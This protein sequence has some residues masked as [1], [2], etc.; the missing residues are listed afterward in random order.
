[1]QVSILVV[2]DEPAIQE[3]I[4][5]NLTLSGYQVLR[6]NDAEAAAALLRDNLPDMMLVDWMLPGQSGVNLIRALRAQTRTRELPIIMLTARGEQQDKILGLESGADDYMTK[7]FSPREMIARIQALLRRRAPQASVEVIEIGGMRLDQ[8]TQRVAVG[9]RQLSLGPTEFRL[10]QHFMSFPERVHSRSTLLDQ[11]WG[12]SV[13]IEERT[14]DTHVGRLRSALEA[15]GHHIMI[16]TVRG[17]GYRLVQPHQKLLPPA[18][19]GNETA[20]G[21]NMKEAGG[22]Y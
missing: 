11:V 7:P 5:I 1:M 6:A 9:T 3:L 13:F 21:L 16:E 2:E 4:A 12:N 22:A 20:L 18:Q 10:L 19:P 8:S 14:V 17:S 15:T